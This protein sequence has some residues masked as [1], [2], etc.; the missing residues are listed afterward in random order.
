V[1][2]VTENELDIHPFV[3][4]N[5]F[6]LPEIYGLEHKVPLSQIYS[7]QIVKKFFWRKVEID[8]RTRDGGNE[9]VTL[10]LKKPE[11]FLAAIGFSEGPYGQQFI[12]KDGVVTAKQI[13]PGI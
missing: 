4:F 9:S 2:Q 1:V 7:A 3:P 12:K 8:F 6:F 5:W 13:D 10:M 11:D